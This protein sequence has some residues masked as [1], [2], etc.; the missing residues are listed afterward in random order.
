ML[1]GNANTIGHPGG[2]SGPSAGN[3]DV[4]KFGAAVIPSQWGGK[5]ALRPDLSEISGTFPSVGTGFEGIVDSIGS[6]DVPNVQ[7][8]LMSKYP[9]DLIIELP[10]AS[11]DYGITPVQ[12]TGP[13]GMSCPEGTTGE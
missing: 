5:G 7:G 4:T 13:S 6:T 8:F 2:F 11:K 10:G 3:I 12:I 9:G 1:Q